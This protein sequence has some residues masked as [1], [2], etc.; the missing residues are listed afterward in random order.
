MRL[1]L[2]ALL[3][4]F[5]LATAPLRAE[6]VTIAVGEWKPF[7]SQDL[8]GYGLHAHRVSEVLE[9]A[10]FEIEYAFVPWTRGYEMTRSGRYAATL[11]WYRTDER[12]REMLFPE[13]PIEIRKSGVYY[14]KSRFPDGLTLASLD[15]VIES[16][17]RV[18][19]IQTYWYSQPLSDADIDYHDTAKSVTA[20]RL[21]N[22]GRGDLYIEDIAVAEADIMAE[23]G[24]E[25]LD[26]FAIAGI[27]REDPMYILFTK[28]DP[29]GETL[30]DAWDA[31]AR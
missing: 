3:A 13:V 18:I 2:F 10:G 8:P 16:D 30:R 7:I 19:G 14:K 5:G 28:E 31:H 17:L 1:G 27:V 12:A 9:T 23:F 26:D 29:I 20:W 21:L 11:S 6:P 24:E 4:V 25:A 22:A 15:D